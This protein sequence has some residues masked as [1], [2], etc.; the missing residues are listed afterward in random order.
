MMSPRPATA[1]AL[2]LATGLSGLASAAPLQVTS[3]D[4]NSFGPS[5]SADGSR[6]AFYSA[7]NLTGQNADNSFEVFVRD[8]SSGQLTQVSEHSDGGFTGGNQTPSISGDGSRIVY[9]H[10]VSSG[11]FSS[12]Q[13]Q[14]YDV[15]SH[16]TATLTPLGGFEQSAISHDGKTIAVDIS[17]VGL[18]LYDTTSQSFVGT[19]TRNPMS[20]AMSADARFVAYQTFGRTM[21]LYDVATGVTTAVGPRGSSFE[22]PALSAD[23][24]SLFFTGD[25][26]PLG[27]NADHNTE[28]FRYDIGTQNLQQ[29]THTTS[30][31]FSGVTASGDGSRI[32]FTTDANLTGGN[33]DGSL[34]VFVYDLLADSFQQVTDTLGSFS[35]SAALSEDGR[36]IAFVSNMNIDGRNPSGASQVFVSELGPQA[37]RDLPEP[38]SLA[39]VALA[40]GLQPVLRRLQ[41]AP[42]APKPDTA[43]GGS[44]VSGANSASSAPRHPAG[45]ASRR[46]VQ[47]RRSPGQRRCL[48]HP[49]HPTFR[50]CPRS[51]RQLGHD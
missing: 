40:L 21:Q 48:N 17:N 3:G 26:D 49:P 30:G 14:T 24:S 27:Q 39:L 2:L 11:G 46:Q 38:A 32:A 28:I 34:E 12:F 25:F 19:V 1:C 51:A 10:F 15:G 47:A 42:T 20:F 44:R 31:N 4:F 16:V 8:R 18:R 9:Q 22:R 23:G 7:S 13:T 35:M 50:G 45:G 43:A 6:L 36:T 5:L 33:A 37:P 41:G 29:V